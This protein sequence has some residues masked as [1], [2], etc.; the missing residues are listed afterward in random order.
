MGIQKSILH[1]DVWWEGLSTSHCHF[2]TTFFIFGRL[3]GFFRQ[4][5][6]RSS[7]ISYVSPNFPGL[8]GISGLPPSK[9][10]HRTILSPRLLNGIL[11]VKTSVATIPKANTSA[12]I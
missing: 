11:L 4:Q 2:V 3:C 9:M 1:K 12:G 10:C 7:H 6:S 5:L 8:L